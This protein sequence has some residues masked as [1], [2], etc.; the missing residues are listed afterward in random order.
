MTLTLDDIKNDINTLSQKIYRL[1]SYLE[2]V[3]LL[4]ERFVDGDFILDIYKPF[5]YDVFD[6]FS[7]SIVLE[8]RI[9]LHKDEHRGIEK[10]FS[11]LEA[12]CDKNPTIL[13]NWP[14]VKSE[15][16][17]SRNKISVIKAN[18][19]KIMD[20]RDKAWAHTDKEVFDNPMDFF[21]KNSITISEVRQ[22]VNGIFD[23]IEYY[24]KSIIGD[25]ILRKGSSISTTN[26]R[27]LLSALEEGNN[28]STNNLLGERS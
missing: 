3:E 15:L 14:A 18:A 8:I 9:L 22:I 19:N 7:G 11:R 26:L 23:I 27:N 1:N 2:V 13:P 28:L 20:L 10:I 4:D 24:Q 25:S 17:N 21:S 6:S 16:V 12:F 5:F